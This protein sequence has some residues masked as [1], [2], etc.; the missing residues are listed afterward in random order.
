MTGKKT[1]APAKA[2]NIT[3]QE[4][5]RMVAEAAYYRAIGRS[6]QNGSPECDWVEAE[7]EVEQILSQPPQK[8]PAKKAAK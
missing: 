5:A 8:A 4:R 3:E 2:T 7:R 1:T 6:F